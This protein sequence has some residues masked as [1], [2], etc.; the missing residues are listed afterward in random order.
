MYI[1]IHID[2][3]VD[4]YIDRYIDTKNYKD[5]YIYITYNDTDAVLN[6]Y[7]DCPLLKYQPVGIIN[8]S[9]V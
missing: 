8:V 7:S 9:T 4:R 5:I 6:R 3:N 2:S 1:Y